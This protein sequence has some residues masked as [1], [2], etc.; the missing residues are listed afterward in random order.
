ML[1][2]IDIASYQ[3]SLVPKAM[4]TTDFIIVKATGGASYKNPC[5]K[6]HADATLAAGKLLGCY[7]FACEY[8]KALKAEQEAAY[9]VAA[10]KPYVGKATLWLDYEMDAL[11]HYDVAW[12]KAWLDEVRAATGAVPGIYMSKSVANAH[13]WSS[14]AKTYPLW[15]AQ[16][17]DYDETGYLDEPWTDSSGFGAWGKPTIFQYTSSGRVAGYGSRLDLNLYY[18]S[19][20]DWAKL[21]GGKATPVKP[22]I[23][24]AEK[25]VR[26]AVA[27]AEDDSHGY[28]Q[29]RRWPSE[30]TDFDCSSLMYWAAHEGGY[31][32]PTGVGYTGTMLA[33]FKAAGFKAIRFSSLSALKRGDILLN[34]ESHTEMCVGGGKFVGA[35]IAETGDIDGA[36]GDQTGN[37]ISV[38]SAYVY[39]DGWAW[40]LRP[41]DEAATETETPAPKPSTNAVRYRVSTDPDGQLWY[42]EMQDHEDTGGSGDDYAGSYGSPITFVACNAKKYRVATEA[43]GWLPWVTAYDISD[44]DKGCAGDGSPVTAIEVADTDIVYSAHVMREVGPTWYEEMQGSRQIDG[45]STDHF[46]GDLANPIDAVRMRRA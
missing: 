24:K 9:F 38:C 28:S 16:Y 20:A 3:E 10:V 7:H 34:V 1:N 5:F 43:G 41:P 17:P 23:T 19:K 46:A 22:T 31:K 18:G 13:D 12:C 11:D 21:A 2:G 45:G 37:E 14:V 15:V 39:S 25:M 42:D 36:P 44:L 6:A 8:G 29:R 33:D 27:V 35:H 32:V 40:V 4:T 26:A 30:G